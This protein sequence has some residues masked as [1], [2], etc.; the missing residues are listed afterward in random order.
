[1]ARKGIL[2]DE[3]EMIYLLLVLVAGSRL[4]LEQ[5][6]ISL[7]NAGIKGSNFVNIYLA[8]ARA[9]FVVLVVFVEK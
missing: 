3:M 4:C 5:I 1:M 2:L 6:C 7:V 9:A 8:F